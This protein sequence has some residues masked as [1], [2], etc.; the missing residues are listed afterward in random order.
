MDQNGSFTKYGFDFRADLLIA[1]SQPSFLGT[2]PTIPSF[3]VLHQP[4][5]WIATDTYEGSFTVE[6]VGTQYGPIFV[7]SQ[8]ISSGTITKME[9]TTSTG[10]YGSISGLSLDYNEVK[11][12]AATTGIEDDIA[13]WAKAFSGDDLL[14]GSGAND[15]LEGFAGNDLLYAGAGIDTLEGGQGLDY[16]G[17]GA[18]DDTLYGNDD[19]DTLVGEA[20]NDTLDGGLGIDILLGGDG[21]DSLYGQSDR[22]LLTGGRGADKLY[23]GDGN[24]AFIFASTKDSS[25]KAS[26]RDTIY[27]FSSKQGDK[28]DLKA[29][30][31]STK[32]GGNQTFKFIGTQDFHKKAGELR[33]E[34]VKGGA[35]LY[36]DVNGDGQSDFSIFAK[37]VTKFMKG[38]FLL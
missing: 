31:A 6:R 33:W 34:K 11:A 16:L 14:N 37:S 26:S 10:D 21:N 22:D 27:D 35:Y 9:R 8:W 38:D 23:G 29:I 30:D 28:I 2:G 5:G 32:S 17:A 36:G 1:A 12:A 3:S 25:I 15:R 7:G 13:L 24:D 20:G 18:G 4:M 19:A